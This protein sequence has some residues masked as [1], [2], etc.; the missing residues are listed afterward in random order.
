[1]DKMNL[2]D[3]EVQE[4]NQQEMLENEGGSFLGAAIAALIVLICVSGCTVNVNVGDGN[5]INSSQKVD[6]TGNNNTAGHGS[7]NF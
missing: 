2:C 1:M 4:M 5:S 3:F 7:G 6:S